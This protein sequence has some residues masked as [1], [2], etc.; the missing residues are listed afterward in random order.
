MTYSSDE[1]YITLV[2]NILGIIFRVMI[3]TQFI[4]THLLLKYYKCVC[5]CVCKIDTVNTHTDTIKRRKS[6]IYISPAKA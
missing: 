5:V 4:I 3:K 1:I 6:S 2:K